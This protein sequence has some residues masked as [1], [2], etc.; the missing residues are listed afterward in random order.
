MYVCMYAL[1]YTT[2]NHT[3][4]KRKLHLLCLKLMVPPWKDGYQYDQPIYVNEQIYMY[5]R[6]W[7]LN[8]A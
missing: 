2:N 6:I 7:G 3:W 5:T 4:C 1:L 8:A